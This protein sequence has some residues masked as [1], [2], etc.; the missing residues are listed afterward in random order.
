MVW[1][2]SLKRFVEP[3][4]QRHINIAAPSASD[5]SKHSETLPLLAHDHHVHADAAEA[6]PSSR[7]ASRTTGGIIQCNGGVDA[8]V[9]RSRCFEFAIRE[10]EAADQPSQGSAAGGSAIRSP[11][12]RRARSELADSERITAGAGVELAGMVPRAASQ[13]LP[14]DA[15]SLSANAAPL[16]PRVRAEQSVKRNDE[17]EFK[18]GGQVP[19]SAS[20][21][22]GVHRP[23][24]GLVPTHAYTVVDVIE[25]TFPYSDSSGNRR[26]MRMVKVG[27]AA[28]CYS[29]HSMHQLVYGCASQF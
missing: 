8:D 9:G 22:P 13:R 16:S 11:A 4:S 28:R 19:Q 15:R 29:S 26:T 5:D 7:R 14:V 27:V 10:D 2:Q 25:I 24:D 17:Q 12:S 18:A 20:T 3:S 23:L 1:L 21:N 6:R